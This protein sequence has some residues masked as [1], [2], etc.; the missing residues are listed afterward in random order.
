VLN[1]SLHEN[2]VEHLN[3][4]IVL[5]TINSVPEASEWLK[6]SFLYSKFFDFDFLTSTG[7]I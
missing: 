5:Q 6:T 4:E 2:L 3:A 7:L 1:P